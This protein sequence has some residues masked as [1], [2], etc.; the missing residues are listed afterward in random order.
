MMRTREFNLGA[1]Y[2]AQRHARQAWDIMD[3]SRR[4]SAGFDRYELISKQR[5]AAYAARE[6]RD[7]Y[8]IT[9]RLPI[10]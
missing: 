7:E 5:E 4:Y 8:A 10:E 9:C 1:A 3:V 6:A 2:M